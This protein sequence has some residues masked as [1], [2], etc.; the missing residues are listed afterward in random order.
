MPIPDDRAYVHLGFLS[1]AEKAGVLAG[2]EALFM[3][4]FFESLSLVLLEA[5][6]LGCPALVDARCEVTRGQ[7]LRSG[8]GKLFDD[9]PSF[10]AALAEL[11]A[12]PDEARRCA[13]AGRAFI[14]EGYTWPR[15]TDAMI[16]LAKVARESGDRASAKR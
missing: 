8:A 5:W 7:T 10:G 12:S 11:L 15:W 14:A 6:A 2:A 16:A 1:E 9:E 3:P 13:E 4:S